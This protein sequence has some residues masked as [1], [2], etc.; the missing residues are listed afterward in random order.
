MKKLKPHAISGVFVFLL[1][2]VFAVLSTVMVLFGANAYKNS[3]S[4]IEE[5]NAGRILAAYARTRVRSCDEEGSVRVENVKGTLT[6]YDDEDHEIIE[7][8]DEIKCLTLVIYRDE[9]ETVVDRIY[10]Y[11]GCLMERMQDESE[12]FEP[13]RGMIVCEAD[14]MDVSIENGLL[15]VILDAGGETLSADVALRSAEV[16]P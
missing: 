5:H 14:A 12:P 7:E 3:G 1:L 6:S 4:R 16:K 9:E 8:T 11:N 2:G 10:V 13:D 15:T